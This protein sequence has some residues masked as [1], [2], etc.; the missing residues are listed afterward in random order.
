MRHLPSHSAL[1]EKLLG[2]APVSG[3]T[4]GSLN[5]ATLTPR[6]QFGRRGNRCNAR[7]FSAVDRP[8]APHGSFGGA[9]APASD[10]RIATSPGRSHEHRLWRIP[11]VVGQ[12]LHRTSLRASRRRGPENDARG[13]VF[14]GAARAVDQA[15]VAPAG[16]ADP[17]DGA[18]T[19]K[20]SLARRGLE[21]AA[22]GRRPSPRRALRQ[23]IAAEP[24]AG[25]EAP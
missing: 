20:F 1:G 17:E 4:A 16:H 15:Q 9:S 8:G 25:E 6:P 13:G 19:R 22:F 24:R 11:S 14:P 18:P 12:T 10:R 23:E 2:V 21:G 3:S 5:S 7:R